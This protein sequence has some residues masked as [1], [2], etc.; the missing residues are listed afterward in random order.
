M[1]LTENRQITIIL[2]HCESPMRAHLQAPVDLTLTRWKSW[3]WL[4]SGV[5]N[6]KLDLQGSTTTTSTTATT[7][8]MTTTTMAT[9]TTTATT[10]M[11]ATTTTM[12]TT[13]TTW[14]TASRTATPKRAF[15]DFF[16]RCCQSKY[17][18]FCKTQFSIDFVCWRLFIIA[19]PMP[20]MVI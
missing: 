12:T 3:P 15:C 4:S 5:V 10:T 16:L 20:V 8:T 2:I 11:A 18:L 6:G 14:T 19:D 9:T 7:T 1:K 17:R 13:T